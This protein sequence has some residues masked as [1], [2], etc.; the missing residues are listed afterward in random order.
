M[1]LIKSVGAVE[2]T[3]IS[4][5]LPTY[6]TWL[7]PLPAVS[8]ATAPARSNL[9]GKRKTPGQQRRPESGQTWWPWLT[10]SW[11]RRRSRWST[12]LGRRN[13]G[14]SCRQPAR[15]RNARSAP[16]ENHKHHLSLSVFS[17][18]F[19]FFCGLKVQCVKWCWNRDLYGLNC[20]LDSPFRLPDKHGDTL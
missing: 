16:E 5:L 19:S 6:Q 20:S 11:G 2:D 7:T 13:T 9:W 4:N 15:R 3:V 1:I 14:S 17:T 18:V 8:L 12:R 10:C